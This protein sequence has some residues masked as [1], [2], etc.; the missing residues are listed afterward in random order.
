MFYDRIAVADVIVTVI[1]VV[2]IVIMSMGLLKS[3]QKSDVVVFSFT[4]TDKL[5]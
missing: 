2:I 5:N 1:I 4:T 3:N